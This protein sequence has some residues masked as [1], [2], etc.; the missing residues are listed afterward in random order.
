MISHETIHQI[1][2]NHLPIR[3]EEKNRYGEVFTHPL[4]IEDMFQHLPSDVWT[5]PFYTW[6]DPNGGVGNFLL[7]AYQKLMIGLEPWEL[8]PEKRSRHILSKMLYTVE[9]NEENIKVLKKVFVNVLHED[10]LDSR[11]FDLNFDIIVGNPPFQDPV[12]NKRVG[13]KN[14]LYERITARC[15]ELLKLG[16]YLLFLTPDNLFS[17]NSVVYK[18]LAEQHIILISFDK[19][20]QRFFP[21]IQQYVCYFLLEKIICGDTLCKIIGN[22]GSGFECCLKNRN[23]NPVRNWSLETELLIRKYLCLNSTNDQIIYH[24]GKPLSSYSQDNGLGLYPLI[25]KPGKKIFVNDEKKSVGFGQKKIVLFV[26][27]PD[28]EFEVDFTGSYGVGPNTIMIPFTDVDDG[29]LLQDFF[30]SNV[31]KT[32]ALATKVTRQF[33]NIKFIQHLNLDIILQKN[34]K[35]KI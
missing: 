7:I 32:L 9:I 33:L 23:V 10:F 29:L 8:D 31:Y 25:Y 28:L 16:G 12:L 2:Y 13:C 35:D 17:G 11:V 27:S 3:L 24:R 4:L 34:K 19:K 6:L 14:K 30:K 1:I 5:N 22:N 20:I 21:K 15:M 18:I 26:I